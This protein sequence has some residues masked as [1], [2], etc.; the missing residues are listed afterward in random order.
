MNKNFRKQ[1]V[2]VLNTHRP[3][4]SSNMDWQK[5]KIPTK[6]P[7]SFSFAAI[8][9][10]IS[11]NFLILE[12]REG[13][14]TK[15]IHKKYCRKVLKELKS[16]LKKTFKPHPLS[17]KYLMLFVWIVPCNSL[18]VK[19]RESAALSRVSH[20]PLLS[21][22]LRP[23]SMIF[24]RT[25]V[26][27]KEISTRFTKIYRSTKPFQAHLHDHYNKQ[28]FKI[29]KKT[30]TYSMNYKNRIFKTFKR[31]KTRRI[32]NLIPSMYPLKLLQ[33][34]P[35]T[36]KTYVVC[37]LLN[38]WQLNQYQDY[39]KSLENFLMC[40]M[41]ADYFLRKL[42]IIDQKNILLGIKNSKKYSDFVRIANELMGKINSCLN[43][44]ENNIY[45]SFLSTE[46][47]TSNFPK[48]NKIPKVL[49]CAP[50]NAAVDE[51]LGRVVFHGFIDLEKNKYFPICLRVGNSDAFLEESS[52]KILV[53][54]K[55]EEFLSMSEKTF[56]E[57]YMVMHNQLMY[58][59]STL[60]LHFINVSNGSAMRS[61]GPKIVNCLN[62]LEN[63]WIEIKRLN[64]IQAKFST[65]SSVSEYR[66]NKQISYNTKKSIETSF[67]SE[68]QLI[69][70]TLSSSCRNLLTDEHLNFQIVLVDEACQACET[71]SLQPF[72][73]NSKRCVM[74]GDPRQLPATV[75]SKMGKQCDLDFSLFSRVLSNT[76][77]IS[78]LTT[79]YRMHP[80]I[81]QYPSEHYYNGK[82]NDGKLAA[83]NTNLLFYKKRFL[84]PYVFFDVENGKERR[85]G[86]S[87]FIN[88]QEALMAL[89]LYIEVKNYKIKLTETKTTKKLTVGIITPYSQQKT[90]IRALFHEVFGYYESAELSIN[91]IDSFQ[92]R[93]LDV[94]IL[95]CVRANPNS[96]SIGFVSDVLRLNVAITRSRKALWVLGN[97]HTLSMSHEWKELLIDVSKR[98]LL[99]GPADVDSYFP[100]HSTLSFKA[101]L[102]VNRQIIK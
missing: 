67:I 32:V 78:M 57:R 73:Y 60:L 40:P 2:V 94:T 51:L 92:G 8:V 97:A 25:L 44:K 87:S 11:E 100:H 77:H 54:T 19:Q 46:N 1:Q 13:C 10:E 7:S 15:K 86:N 95:S 69:F 65:P 50:S 45:K 56:H 74:I 33:G 18:V 75:I 14:G 101:K 30:S 38:I 96:L 88:T 6:F 4:K 59:L 12:F 36:G 62:F 22:I 52:R 37:G 70:A 71:S 63:I 72:V 93:Q 91:T 89:S 34:P 68:A 24:N 23:S 48:L 9:R 82:L 26:K 64:A 16:M 102:W 81:R 90:Y 35:G 3:S 83:S 61:I 28:Q 58:S 49:I 31:F 5:N 85:S 55:L 98:K 17:S 66:T 41:V 21:C 43:E 27:P 47:Q 80:F 99:V 42:S 76:C 53:E 39:Y 79:Q 29:I 84:K 20:S